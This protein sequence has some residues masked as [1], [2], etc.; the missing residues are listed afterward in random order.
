VH[1]AAEYAEIDST[2]RKMSGDRKPVRPR[3]DNRYI[4]DLSHDTRY[5]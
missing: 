5:V 3:A 4:D 1:R 2:S